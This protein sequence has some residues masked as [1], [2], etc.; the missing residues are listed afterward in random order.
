M[1][2]ANSRVT[3]LLLAIMSA[4]PSS[5]V[6]AAVFATDWLIPDA[7]SVDATTAAR[8]E[9]HLVAF[10]STSPHM[11]AWLPDLP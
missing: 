2:L 1:D 9:S 6:P 7:G 5:G 11:R 4:A 8:G 10:N 3:L